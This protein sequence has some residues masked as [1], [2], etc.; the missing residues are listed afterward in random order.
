MALEPKS[1]DYRP[2]PNVSRRNFTQELLEVPAMVRLL[3][4]PSRLRMLEVGCGRGVAL[5]A[6]SRL[7]APTRLTGIDIDGSALAEAA[8]R[9]GARSIGADLVLGDVRNMPFAN[10]SFD[11]VIDFGTCYHI[12]NSESALREIV[13]VLD[14]RGLFVYETPANQLMSHP[15]RSFGR[16]LPWGAAR[17]LQPHKTR[18]LW[19]SRIKIAAAP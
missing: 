5:P 7:C 1:E 14:G 6:L 17:E 12:S 2:F 19:S 4:L 8:G 10:G 13:R 15:I 16:G 11:I 18:I 3:G 9:L